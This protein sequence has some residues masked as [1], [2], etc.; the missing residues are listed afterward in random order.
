MERTAQASHQD[1]GK[2]NQA[3]QETPFQGLPRISRLELT[4]EMQP[5]LIHHHLLIRAQVGTPPLKNFNL[6]RALRALV[7]RVR[8]KILQ[9]PNTKYCS[10]TGNT[11][12]SGSVII[13][14]SSITFHCWEEVSPAV[15]HLDIY[16]CAPF[17]VEDVLPW[18]QQFELEAVDYKFLDRERGFSEIK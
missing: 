17:A 14:T 12:W 11:G 15:I 1:N 13:S 10:D 7:K 6:A 3:I 18:L 9:G 8:M 5:T 16:S 4:L 2:I